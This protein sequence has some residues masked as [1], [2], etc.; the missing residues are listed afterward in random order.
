MDKENE[1]SGEWGRHINRHTNYH[2]SDST[3]L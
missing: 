2:N 3:E 1:Y